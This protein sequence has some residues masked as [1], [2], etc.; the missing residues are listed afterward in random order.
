[1]QSAHAEESQKD[2]SHLKSTGEYLLSLSKHGTQL[3]PVAFGYRS[4]N[5]MEIKYHYLT[6]KVVAGRWATGQNCRFLWGFFFYWI[7]NC[8]AVKE[9]IEYD[10]CIIMVQCW[11]KELPGYD[12]LPCTDQTE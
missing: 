10:G 2:N 8:S 6:G 12:F 3:K 11:A 1:M 4:C 9:I 7:C 5:D